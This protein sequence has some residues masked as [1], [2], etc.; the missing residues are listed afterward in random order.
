METDGWIE[1]SLF[2]KIRKAVPL[3]AVDILAV[4]DG[5]LLLMLR[6]NEPGKDLWFVPGG[7]VRLG[8]TLERA[9][10]RVI[11]EETS[12]KCGHIEKK[13][14]MTHFWP[15]AHYV[16]IFFRAEAE[17]DDVILDAQ[18][19][20]FKWISRPPEDLHPYLRQMIKESRIF[21]KDDY[22]SK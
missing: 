10:E 20:A 3:V 13:G 16:S 6:N 11:S 19:R 22:E 1:R 14:S 4:N 12:L 9:A 18:H 5:R 8:E 2:M 21:E 7:R 17:N 15:E